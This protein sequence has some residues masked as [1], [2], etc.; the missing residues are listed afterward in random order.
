[1]RTRSPLPQ[2]LLKPRAAYAAATLPNPIERPPR[3]QTPAKSLP[4]G[5]RLARLLVLR[6]DVGL[7]R[8]IQH[9]LLLLA[10]TRAYALL[11]ATRFAE[12]RAAPEATSAALS[13]ATIEDAAT[14]R[15][16]RREVDHLLLDAV[17]D[18]EYGGHGRGTLGRALDARR[19]IDRVGGGKGKEQCR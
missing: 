5:L 9:R 8:P 4:D 3:P 2:R 14:F 18:R 15:G 17:G 7:R 19:H 12:K 13:A 11:R 1:M 10:I 16:A 6:L